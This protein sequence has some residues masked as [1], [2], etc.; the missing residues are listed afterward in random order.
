M[1]VRALA[2]VGVALLV[3]LVDSFRR[4]FEPRLQGGESD[5]YASEELK[6]TERQIMSG[7]SRPA[8]TIGA[9]APLTREDEKDMKLALRKRG[10]FFINIE[11]AKRMY[12][13]GMQFFDARVQE[14]YDA[15]HIKGAVVLDPTDD[16]IVSAKSKP[17]VLKK[18][19]PRLPVVIYCSGGDCDSSQLIGIV[20][21]RFGF[22]NVNVFE[23]GFPTWDKKGYPVERK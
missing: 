14:E 23:E 22:S 18:F 13:L 5:I 4:P 21:R 17:E 6:E 11:E 9:N 3:G 7:D 16:A 8:G 1:L 2:I 19:D 15:G 12:D 20:L 10:G